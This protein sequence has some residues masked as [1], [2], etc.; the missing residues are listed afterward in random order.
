[1]SRNCQPSPWILAASSLIWD[2]QEPYICICICI[3][4]C[5]Q[6]G[7]GKFVVNLPLIAVQGSHR[8]VP[9]GK[10]YGNIA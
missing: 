10:G 9:S 5:P 3:T 7:V 4:S 8:A 6:A 2:K 1:M